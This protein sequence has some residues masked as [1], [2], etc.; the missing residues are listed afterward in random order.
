MIITGGENVFPI[1]IE[2]VLYQHPKVLGAVIIGVPDQIWGE[3]LKAVVVLKPGVEATPEEL[4]Q[5]CKTKLAVYKVPKSV[6]FVNAL[7]MSSFGKILRRE[8][9]QKYWAGHSVKI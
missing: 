7:P 5:Y 3:A 1:E 4:I 2:E 9:R 8:V 6:D